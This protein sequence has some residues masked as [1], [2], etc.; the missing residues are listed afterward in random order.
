MFELKAQGPITPLCHI[1]AIFGQAINQQKICTQ[2]HSISIHDQCLKLDKFIEV[3]SVVSKQKKDEV[4]N[5][6]KTS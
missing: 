1:T 6:N 2:V 4:H 5:H 3:F